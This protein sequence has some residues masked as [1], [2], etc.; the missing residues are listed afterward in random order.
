MQEFDPPSYPSVSVYPRCKIPPVGDPRR[1]QLMRNP[2]AMWNA[3]LSARTRLPDDLHEAM[4][5]WSFDPKQSHWVQYYAD[6]VDH[7]DSMRALRENFERQRRIHDWIL[8]GLMIASGVSLFAVLLL[9]H[10]R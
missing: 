10:L 1:E 5:L 6:W 4:M 2:E 3:S 9:G 8:L 7:C